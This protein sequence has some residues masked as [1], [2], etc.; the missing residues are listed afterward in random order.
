[1]AWLADDLESLAPG[2]PVVTFSHIPL[3]SSGENIYGYQEDGPAPTLLTVDGE[4]S[5]QHT[6]RNTADILTELRQHDYTLA[7]SGHFHM[8]DKL[9]Y[10]NHGVQTRF[11]MSSAVRNDTLDRA[12]MDLISGLFSTRSRTA[13]STK[14]PSFRWTLKTSW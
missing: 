14:E 8:R 11:Y 6:V 2:T 5:F 1:M 3:I 4:T 13:R 12:G 7:L 9:F 10:E